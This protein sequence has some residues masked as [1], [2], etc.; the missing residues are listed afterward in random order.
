MVFE[1]SGSRTRIRIGV[2]A[3][4]FSTSSSTPKRKTTSTSPANA[5]ARASMQTSGSVRPSSTSSISHGLNFPLADVIYRWFPGPRGPGFPNC[6][7]PYAGLGL[8]AA[9]PHV[10]SEVREK[11]HEGYQFHGPGVEGLV[12]VNVDLARHWGA[13]FEYKITYANLGE[14]DIPNGSIELTPLTHNLVF[15]IT[16]RY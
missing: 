2:L 1:D 5:M 14:L 6:L 15:G 8:G 12:G 10:E 3:G 9:I 13:M 11:F 7:Q 16:F 4:N